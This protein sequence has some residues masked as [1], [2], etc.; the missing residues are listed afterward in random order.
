MMC[1]VYVENF[2]YLFLHSKLFNLG[3]Y[4]STSIVN[5]YP[6]T[7]RRLSSLSTL[8]YSGAK[9]IS[10]YLFPIIFSGKLT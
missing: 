7:V 2:F 1:C 3:F 6:L 9:L 10:L 4:L 8:S 5:T